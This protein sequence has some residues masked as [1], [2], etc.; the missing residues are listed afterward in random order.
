MDAAIKVLL[1]AGYSQQA[2]KLAKANQKQFWVVKIQ[3]EELQAWK[4]CAHFMS[5]LEMDSVIDICSRY[6]MDLVSALPEE[7]AGILVGICE[8]REDAYAE[9]FVHLFVNQRQWCI[10]FLQ[11]VLKNWGIVFQ[12]RDKGKS[13]QAAT[14]EADVI[15]SPR[16]EESC[17]KICNTLLE[18]YLLDES[19]HV[20]ALELL[21]HPKSLYDIDHALVL[22]RQRGFLDAIIFLYEKMEM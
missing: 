22:S 8:K 5:T 4:D 13:K 9:D 20:A 15:L 16:E 3:V 7:M 1:P 17:R 12:S 19:H 21:S 18:F 14:E 2:L 10:E 6:G 11:R